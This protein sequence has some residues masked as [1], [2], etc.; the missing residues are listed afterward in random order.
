[1]TVWQHDAERCRPSYIQSASFSECCNVAI[2]GAP[3][4]PRSD[5]STERLLSKSLALSEPNTSENN[6][7]TTGP[8][9]PKQEKDPKSPECKSP[10]VS[11]CL[12]PCAANPASDG[13]EYLDLNDSQMDK[14]PGVDPES[15][16][17]S[18]LNY[19][20]M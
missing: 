6:S 8:E 16:Y 1:M 2:T 4:A 10:V 12:S 20:I 18:A 15:R 9:S 3:V 11:P 13:I 19:P 7:D 5:S 17:Q 14:W